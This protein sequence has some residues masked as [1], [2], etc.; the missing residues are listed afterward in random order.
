VIDHWRT[1]FTT[2]VTVAAGLTGLVFVALSINLAKIITQRVLVDRAGE[3]LLLLSQ[4]IV[5]GLTVLAPG[6]VQTTGITLCA[7]S[8]AFAIIITSLLVRG[9]PEEG[10]MRR[11]FWLRAGLV[12][13]SLG[14]VVAGSVLL[15]DGAAAPYGWIGFGALAGIALGIADGWVL[16]IE[17]LR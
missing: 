11:P 12:E 6:S 2:E 17:I 5:L 10:P 16:L 1:F 7:I 9:R 13:A 8:V 15:A 14:S 4:P 3:A